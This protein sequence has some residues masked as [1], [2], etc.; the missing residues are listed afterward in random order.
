MTLG[1]YNPPHFGLA[2]A[3]LKLATAKKLHKDG[4]DPAGLAVEKKREH[5]AAE[6]ISELS[7]DYLKHARAEGKRS[8]DEDERILNKDVLPRW[9]NRKV[10]EI[11][12]KDVVALL[13]AVAGRGANI[14]ANRTYTVVRALFRYALSKAIV[15]TSP[16]VEIQRRKEQARDRW[17]PASEIKA[18]WE[19]FDEHLEDH[20]ALGLQFMFATM[21]R[22]GEAFGLHQREVD[23]T[24]GIWTL[25]AERSKNGRER[26]IPLSPLA[27]RILSRCKP[28]ATGFYFPSPRSGEPYRGQSIDHALRDL[29]VPRDR[30]RARRRGRPNKTPLR[31]PPLA[32]AMQPFTPHDIRR[33]SST[34][35]RERG[36]PRDYVKALLGH[37]IG[38]VTAVYDRYD[39][40]PEKKAAA[41]VLGTQ[42]EIILSGSE[43]VLPFAVA[44]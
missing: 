37:L 3:N 9:G 8:A 33:S 24:A 12:R 36:V 10:A 4:Q 15:D 40:L 28:S 43:N 38:D 6:T 35:A 2:D 22:K 29:F 44:S 13:D 23:A 30:N 20:I 5:R 17:L 41:A 18:A 1:T 26:L 11:A 21:A 25:P 14:Q 16:C 39:M 32:E 19:A 34:L 7:E 31:T 27:L 42:L